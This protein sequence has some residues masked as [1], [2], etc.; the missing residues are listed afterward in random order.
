MSSGNMRKVFRFASDV[1]NIE[2]KKKQKKFLEEQIK[3]TQVG[4]FYCTFG[5]FRAK[6][7]LRNALE[8]PG[9]TPAL[10]KSITY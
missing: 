5:Q 2:K 7:T 4:A 6:Q 1:G 10:I 3:K 9:S 8:E